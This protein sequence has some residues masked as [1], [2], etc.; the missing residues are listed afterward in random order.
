MWTGKVGKAVEVHQVEYRR[1]K[2]GSLSL[3]HSCALGGV[4]GKIFVHFCFC[5]NCC[6]FKEG[7]GME[8]GSE[9]G[10]FDHAWFWR[11]FQLT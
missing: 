8:E 1:V 10:A 9:Q 2:S 5:F 3:N 4:F 7:A 11:Q 6:F